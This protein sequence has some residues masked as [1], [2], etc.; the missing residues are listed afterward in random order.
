MKKLALVLG[1]ALGV[2]CLPTVSQADLVINEIM[3]NPS[4]VGDSSGE[5]FEIFNS[6][7]STVDLDGYEFRDNGS[8]SFLV[9]GLLEIVAGGYLVFGNNGD[10]ATNG[11][12]TVDYVYSGM[13]LANGDDELIL[14]DSNDVELDRVEWDGG[15]NFPD[16]TGASMELINPALDNNVGSNWVES[17]QTFGDG[18]LGTPGA[19]NSAIPEPGSLAVLLPIALTL[20][21]RRRK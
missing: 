19:A 8:D 4:A 3:Q 18:D 1:V 9:S 13:F 5:W 16:P 2:A 17:T 14:S 7:S 15:P 10:S 20:V 11:G 12:V 6:G 21:I